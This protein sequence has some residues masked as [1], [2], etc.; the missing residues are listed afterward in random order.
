ML[1]G[2]PMKK[3]GTNWSE[4]PFI[5][6]SDKIIHMSSIGIKP[7]EILILIFSLKMEMM[8]Q[9]FNIPL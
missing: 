9:V 1:K 3:D 8:L 7:G 5:P 4:I 6:V 2:S